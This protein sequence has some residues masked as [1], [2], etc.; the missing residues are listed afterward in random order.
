MPLLAELIEH[1][2]ERL[3]SYNEHAIRR[4]A[5][6]L[7]LG[8]APIVRASELGVEGN[9]TRLLIDL[10]RAVDGTAYLAG[11]GAGGYQEDA[12]F[13]EAGIDLTFQGFEPPVYPQLANE[14][15]PGLSIIDALM[16]CGADGVREMLNR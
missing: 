1:G 4:L 8:D 6:A 10:V 7:G 11:G 16:Q 5:H 12:L 13:A 15:V 3:A 2:A 9:A 14:P